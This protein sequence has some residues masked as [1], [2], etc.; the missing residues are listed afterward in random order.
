MES[1]RRMSEALGRK[2]NED[3][4]GNGYEYRLEKRVMKTKIYKSIAKSPW[5]VYQYLWSNI[6]RGARLSDTYSIYTDY[7]KAGQLACCPNVDTIASE[8]GIDRK[9]ASRYLQELSDKNIIQIITKRIAPNRTKNI[10]VLGYI[11]PRSGKEEF[12]FEREVEKELK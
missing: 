4:H 7:F 10:Y 3:Y 6:V 12:F 1:V 8:C 2:P 11:N 9:T 5:L